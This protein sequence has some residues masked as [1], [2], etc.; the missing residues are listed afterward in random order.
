MERKELFYE[1]PKFEVVKFSK[2]DIITTTNET[3]GEWDY[4]SL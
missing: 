2:E 1:Q 3:P 4:F